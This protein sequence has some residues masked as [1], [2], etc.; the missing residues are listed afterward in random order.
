[1]VILHPPRSDDKERYRLRNRQLLQVQY[2]DDLKEPGSVLSHRLIG[3]LI[4]YRQGKSVRFSAAFKQGGGAMILKGRLLAESPIYRGNARKTLFTR[5]GDGTQRLVSLAGEIEGTAEALMDAFIGRS[6]SGKNIGLLDQLWL[7]LYRSPMPN[8]LVTKVSCS[9]QEK[10]YSKDHLFDIRMGIKLNEDRWAAEANANYKMETLF[11]NSAFDFAMT[12]NDAVLKGE[13]NGLKLYFLLQELKEGRFW[14][15]AG[16]SKG[17]GRCRLEIELPFAPR[18]PMPLVSRQAN[19]LTMSLSFNLENPV[20]VGWPWGKIDPNVP[21]FAAIDGRQLIEAMRDIPQPV[22]K[23]L[24]TSIG[25]PILSPESWKKKFSEFLPRIIAIWLME[26]SSKEE[27]VW[28]LPSAPLEKL[29]KGKLALSQKLMDRIRPLADRQFPSREAVDA[30]LKEALG[31]KANM[32]KRVLDVLAHERKKGNRFDPEA[33]SRVADAMGFDRASGD[34]L[35]DVIQDEAALTRILSQECQRILP[36]L[37]Q[38]V[39]QQVRLVQSD[40]WI[41]EE[42]AVREE[43]LQVKTLLSRGKIEEWQWLNPDWTPEGIRSSTWREFIE[44]HQRVQFR[45]MLN[46]RNLNKSMAND[47]NVI[48]LLKGYRDHTRRELSQPYNTD[49]RAGGVSSREISRKYGKPYDT[50][51]MRMLSWAPSTHEQGMWEVYIPGSTVKGAFRKRAS[52]LLKTLWGESARTTSVLNRLFGEQGQRGLVYFSDAYLADSP[53]SGRSWCSMDGVKMDPATGGPIEEAKADYLFAFGK[54]ISFNLRLDTQDLGERDLEVFSILTHLLDDFRKGDIPLGG[55]KTCGF[56]WVKGMITNITWKTGSPPEEDSIGKKLFKNQTLVRDGLWYGLS[57]EGE[58]AKDALHAKPLVPEGKRD[59]QSPPRARQGF[60]S[61]SAFGG[62]CGTLAI[63][64][65]V[66]TPTSI[67][68]SGEPSFVHVSDDPAGGT[69]NGWETFAMAPPE[70]SLRDASRLYALPSKSLKGMV[71]HI[72]S[73]ASDS[74][75]ASS[76]I[77]RLNPTDSLF[78]WVGSGPNQAIMGRLSFD[79]APFEKVETAWFK[80]PYPYGMWHYADGRWEK[81]P[82][83]KASMLHIARS[84]RL[85]PH[86]PLAPC[87]ERLDDF[88]PDTPKADYVKAILPGSLCRFV[89]RFWNLEK[90]ELQRL[91]WCVVLEQGAAHKI[92]KGRYLGFGSLRLRLLP[93]SFLT[94]WANRYSGKGEKERTGRLPI[95]LKEWIDPKVIHHYQELRKALDAQRI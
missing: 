33:W 90:E 14:F 28:F 79:F 51:F 59:I 5:D 93:E 39:D 58:A 21:A 30:A 34:R 70:S 56:G 80:V 65:E 83:Q 18:E 23:R 20:L 16:K 76:D 57:I 77:N 74:S 54:D 46:S 22:R 82:Q 40:S 24:E 49:F 85:F 11:K 27:E 69:I 4:P 32:A 45:H 26:Q 38:Q 63:E 86:A 66:L 35:A 73:I 47:K 2:A 55:E 87:V 6:R 19:H 12:V 52:Q 41:D 29:G 62:Y 3:K 92:G 61:H 53:V 94:D 37:F 7:R 9:L 10:S 95:N 68:E 25:G 75:N 91:L 44:S 60:I 81:A 8:G 78:G 31:S 15:G 17:L 42:I 84:W 72:Y 13:D 89:L 71:R 67:K 50:V 1:M 36:V 43:H 64:G 88:K 48:A